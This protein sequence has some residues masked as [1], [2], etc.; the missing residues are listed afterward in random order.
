MLILP[1][2]AFKV[3]EGLSEVI[4]ISCK[5]LETIQTAF[6]PHL[7]PFPLFHSPSS[8]PLQAKRMM[9]TLKLLSPP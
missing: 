5:L 1:F 4:V 7:I 6:S 2:Q 9:K 3:V 8:P